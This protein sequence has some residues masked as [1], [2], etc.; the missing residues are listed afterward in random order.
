MSK[1]SNLLTELTRKRAYHWDQMQKIDAAILS[2]KG[3]DGIN[4]DPAQVWTKEIGPSKIAYRKGKLHPHDFAMDYIRRKG[5]EVTMKELYRAYCDATNQKV[6]T[7]KPDKF[8][9]YQAFG[10]YFATSR[11]KNKFV[12]KLYKIDGIGR[13]LYLNVDS[14]IKLQ[15]DKTEQAPMNVIKE[16]VS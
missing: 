1:I 5:N 11:I 7:N 4:E 16:M 3:I 14:A 12:R 8:K 13:E 9:H 6:P 10:G 15:T 2:L